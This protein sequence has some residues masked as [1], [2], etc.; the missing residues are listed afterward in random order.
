MQAHIV[1]GLYAGVSAPLI[2]VTPMCKFL[3]RAQIVLLLMSYSCCQ[4]LGEQ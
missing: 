3:S 1:Q 2:G 4:L